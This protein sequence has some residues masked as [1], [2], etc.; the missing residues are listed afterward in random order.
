[1]TF[2]CSGPGLFRS[3]LP[4]EHF[5]EA[6]DP[7][8]LVHI[9][10]GRQYHCD[11]RPLPFVTGNRVTASRATFPPPPSPGHTTSV[12][13]SDNTPQL[14]IEVDTIHGQL[15]QRGHCKMQGSRC[16]QHIRFP[17][18]SI[19]HNSTQTCR[20][21]FV[22]CRQLNR[23]VRN[24]TKG[25]R[26]GNTTYCN[27]VLHVQHTCGVP[28]VTSATC[29]CRWQTRHRRQR[30]FPN[31]FRTVFIYLC[32]PPTAATIPPRQSQWPLLRPWTMPYGLQW[33]RFQSQRPRTDRVGDKASP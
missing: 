14:Q 8:Y 17:L 29:T 32:T 11:S 21:P 23:G 27:E 31:H 18:P 26:Q 3:S 4:V 13:P 10:T 15:R 28:C 12:Q 6:T 5:Y 1:M 7:K 33:C 22:R 20:T 25:V 24:D 2:H 30:R 9:Q 16:K 19:T